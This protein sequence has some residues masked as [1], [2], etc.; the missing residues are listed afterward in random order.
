M[1]RETALIILKDLSIAIIIGI[2]MTMTIHNLSGLL[3]ESFV[4]GFCVFYFFQKMFMMINRE[5]RTIENAVEAIEALDKLQA[6]KESKKPENLVARFDEKE[7]KKILNDIEK[8][9][10]TNDS[11]AT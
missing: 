3:V 2:A 5:N 4:I 1:N 11:D 9:N 10:K 8:D 7:I 6:I